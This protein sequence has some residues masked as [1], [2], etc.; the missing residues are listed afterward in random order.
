MKSAQQQEQ[1]IREIEEKSEIMPF[2]IN[3]TL[4]W[5]QKTSEGP[6]VIHF[7]RTVSIDDLTGL[8]LGLKLNLKFETDYNTEPKI[9]VKVVEG[10]ELLRSLSINLG[11]GSLNMSFDDCYVPWIG[12]LRREHGFSNPTNSKTRCRHFWAMFRGN[13]PHKIKDVTY[14]I[15]LGLGMK[16][17]EIPKPKEL[18]HGTLSVIRIFVYSIFLPF[19]CQELCNSIFIC[20]ITTFTSRP[21]SFD[22]LLII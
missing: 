4:E 20:G 9:N 7:D 14:S 2:D 3:A 6:Y 19:S 12:E 13:V 8:P 17:I 21:L 10:L 15:R 1:K 16:Q 18:K 22:K 11:C 5:E